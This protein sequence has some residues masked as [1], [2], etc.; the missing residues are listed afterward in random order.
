MKELLLTR[1]FKISIWRKN[2]HA[3]PTGT[4]KAYN[5]PNISESDLYWQVNS[6][7]SARGCHRCSGY[8]DHA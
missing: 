2:S 5:I 7:F 4:I 6:I 1:Q 3:L 8:S